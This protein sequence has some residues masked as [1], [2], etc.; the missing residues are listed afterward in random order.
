MF[1]YIASKQLQ[2][3]CGHTAV[4]PYQYVDARQNHVGSARDLKEEG[5]WV[6]QRGD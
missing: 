3:K 2:D 1:T 6:H 4:D 5:G